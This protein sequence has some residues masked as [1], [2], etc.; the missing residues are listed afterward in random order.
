MLVPTSAVPFLSVMV[1]ARCSVSPSEVAV[2]TAGASPTHVAPKL[3][4]VR[5]VCPPSSPISWTYVATV[6]SA[7]QT[8]TTR[9]II[10]AAS[11]TLFVVW[12]VPRAMLT[13]LATAGRCHVSGHL[14]RTRLFM[15]KPLLEKKIQPVCRHENAT[16]GQRRPC[17]A[18]DDQAG[19]E[20]GSADD[21]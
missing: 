7:A 10:R 5:R 1:A 4:I 2:S 16:D 11:W 6:A 13:R 12:T 19:H 9:V 17:A 3:P 14:D 8:G 20:C 21:H 18:T 15:A